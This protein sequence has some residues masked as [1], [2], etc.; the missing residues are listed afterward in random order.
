MPTL[1]VTARFLEGRYH[2]RPDWPP[3]PARLFQALVAGAARGARLE[4]AD[5]HALQWLEKLEPPVVSAPPAREGAG[6]VN[7]VP[8][9]DLDS[10]DGDPG[11]VGELRVGKT[12]RPRY[13][14]AAAP[15]HYL[16]SF[17]DSSDV[18]ALAERIG[19]IAERL[20]QLG[21]GVDMAHAQA[22]ILDDDKASAFRFSER[23]H[24]PAPIDGALPLACP[25]EG[26]LDSLTRRHDAFRNRFRGI[27]SQGRKS[28][29]A[30]AQPPKP[31][32]RIVGYDSPA[33]LLLFD[34]RRMNTEKSE[35]PF[36]P[37]PLTRIGK[38]VAQLRDA[39]AKRLRDALPPSQAP[40]VDA[41]VIGRAATEADKSSRIRIIPLPSIGFA[42]A[43]RAIR[44]ILI[45]VPANCPLRADDIEWAFSDFSV[46]DPETGEIEW[47]LIRATERK[48]LAQYGVDS[49]KGSRL[50]RSVTPLALPVRRGAR[51]GAARVMNEADAAASVRE[52]LR[53]EGVAQS[54]LA[55]RVQREPF[56]ANG[57][58][59]ESFSDGRFE[60]ARLWHVEIDFASPVRGPLAL[61]DGRWL[62]L[63]L[64][65]PERRTEGVLA[66]SI[67]DGLRPA[68]DPILVARALR[69]AVMARVPLRSRKQGLPLFFTGHAN[70]EEPARSGAHDHIACMFDQARLRLLIFAPHLLE[71][72]RARADE[73]ENWRRLEEAM[74]R[75]EQLRAGAAGLLRVALTRIDLDADPLFAPSREWTSVTPYRVLRHRKRHDAGQAL[76]E[77]LHGERGRN[78]LPEAEI[79]V[80]EI[81]GRGAGLAG[82]L[83]LRFSHA[84]PGPI[85]IGRD[86]HF[87]GGLFA[88]RGSSVRSGRHCAHVR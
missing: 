38:L 80:V 33:R 21:Q 28:A 31:L 61:G 35:P 23:A 2:G 83:T 69:R 41:E 7:F 77:D 67:V 72:R 45:V 78:S 58:K 65:A 27:A 47:A 84:V 9:N 10:V 36:A 62:G 32:F 3:S 17:D 75:F 55:I 88:G 54:A 18:R 59:A 26:S 87:G 49:D 57:A 68:A 22:E 85:L 48:M 46:H 39:V 52:A 29:I 8:N 1:L 16:W 86:R 82:K 51:N 66:F 13:F 15:L 56:D 24:R 30:F 25:M 63:G 70:D 5:R 11:R 34:I 60:R 14:D 79:A 74:S 76:I 4:D 44:R 20:Y 19:S 40:L 12:I 6:F 37:Q 53:H 43:D 81:D 73:S 50:W 42:H 71:R 64:M